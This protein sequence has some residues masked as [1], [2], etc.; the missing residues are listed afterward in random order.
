MRM[1]RKKWVPSELNG[2]PFYI[3]DAQSLRGRWHGAFPR[4]APM[5]LEIGCGRGVSS[6]PMA[7]DAPGVNF[8]LADMKTDML[9]YVRRALIREYGD[10]ERRNAL[11]TSMDAM[12]LSRYMDERDRVERIYLNFSN[13]WDEKRRHEKR[14][15]T[16]PRQLMQYRQ[17]LSPGGEIW[18]KTDSDSLFGDSLR[19]FA[20]CGFRVR[21]ETRDLHA[22]GFAPN[23]VSEHEI[24]YTQMGVP[25]KFAIAVKEDAVPPS[26]ADG[27]QA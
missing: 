18:F 16:H 14:R 27:I 10:D 17:I 20:A 3:Q 23:Y 15:L 13:P 4:P 24:M 26:P 19:Y 5:M 12:F 6:A 7:K 1:R 21:Y 8:I 25:I 2:C 22:S 11:I 9:G